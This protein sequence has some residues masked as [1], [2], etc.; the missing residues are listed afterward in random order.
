[1]ATPVAP[2]DTS[3]RAVVRNYFI[4]LR[5]RIRTDLEL[6]ATAAVRA[7]RAAATTGVALQAV[8]AATPI[9]VR[10][11]SLGECNNLLTIS[12]PRRLRPGRRWWWWRLVKYHPHPYTTP[13]PTMLREEFI[14]L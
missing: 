12:R 11:S 1:V 4:F 5:F 6:Q 9:R 13:D 8:A 2:A 14:F 3:N 10:I 7:A